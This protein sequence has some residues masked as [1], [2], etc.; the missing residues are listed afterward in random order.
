MYKHV[1]PQKQCFS[2]FTGLQNVCGTVC[3]LSFNLWSVFH[4]S[5]S[6]AMK[7]QHSITSLNRELP[8]E[9]QYKPTGVNP[10]AQYYST[11]TRYSKVP[12]RTVK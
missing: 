1:I 7:M 4:P 9:R 2:M 5:I 11:S 8:V 6:V 3:G 12:M 10:E